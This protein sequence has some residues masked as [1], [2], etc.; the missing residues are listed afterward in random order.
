MDEASA[1]D[2]EAAVLAARECFDEGSW[3]ATPVAERAALLTRTADLLQRDR[4]GIARTETLDTGKTLPESRID[5]DDVTAVFRY[6]AEEVLVDVDRTVDVGRDDVVSRVVHQPVGA[7][8]LIAPWN[9]PLLQMSWKVAPALA[10]GNTVVLKPSEVT[11]LSTVHLA[12]LL[13]EA[14]STPAARSS[15]RRP[16]RS[17]A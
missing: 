6:Y 1:A 13:V 3:P 16:T 14:G 12:R 5:I 7:C 15:R 8:S 11:P 2:A 9:Y 4:E 10:A 17:S